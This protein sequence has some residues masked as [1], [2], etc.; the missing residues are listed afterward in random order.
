[1]TASN[2]TATR[3][4]ADGRDVLARVEDLHLYFDTKRG[5]VKALDGVSFELRE[6]EILSLVGETGCGKTI[7]GRSF[8][9]LVP[10]PPGRY[11]EGEVTVRSEEEC[12]PCGGAGCAACHGT[13]YRFDDVLSMSKKQMRRLRG[14]RISMIFQDPRTTLNPSLTIGNH[15]AESILA[16]QGERILEAAGVD[17]DS[18]DG[19]SGTLLRRQASTERTWL[20]NLVCELPPLRRHAKAIERE[21]REQ[22]VEV[23]KDTQIPNPREVLNDY[24]HELSGGQ[25]Q[26]VMIAM[27]L[28]SRPDLLIADEATTALDVTTQARILELL[29]DLQEKYGTSI[30]YITHD[31]TLVRRIADRVAVMYAGN[32]AE[33]GSVERVYEN[34]QHPYT[35]GLLRSI[36][37]PDSVN[38]QL[39]GIEGTIPDLTNP[40]AGCRFCTRCP[41]VM[42]HCE[43]QDPPTVETEPGHEVTCHLFGD[44]ASTGLTEEA[45]TREPAE[46]VE[47]IDP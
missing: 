39:R 40:P 43:S 8:M 6:G 31:L 41:E 5:V 22:S 19:L 25:Q 26:R 14:N 1:M 37:T 2:G 27:A 20:E 24:P 17:A 18:M 47:V 11:P 38:E 3:V 29:K 9:Q 15:V 4:D 36:P 28:V 21:V 45:A 34:P 12:G 10:T 32:I 46:T 30:L 42:D 7:T 35:R 13:G 44:E 33:L 16:H 23:L